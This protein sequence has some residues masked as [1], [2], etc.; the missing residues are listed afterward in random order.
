M[1]NAKQLTLT[2]PESRADATEIR[3]TNVEIDFASGTVRGVCCKCTKT[4]EIVGGSEYEFVC[5]AGSLATI[6]N[7]VMDEAVA[8]N[9]L[10][11]GTTG[12][13]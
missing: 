6:E 9:Q 4:G 7:L 3:L 1:A 8:A 12:A 10:P 11:A 2:T 5:P 13:I